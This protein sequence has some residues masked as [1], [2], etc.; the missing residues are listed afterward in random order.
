MKLSFPIMI[1]L[2]I[3]ASCG[4]QID[5]EPYMVSPSQFKMD[6]YILKDGDEVEIIGKSD[7]VSLEHKIDFYNLV[8]V[9]SI[10]TGD[11]INVL[12]TTFIHPGKNGN[13]MKFISPESS[14]GLILEAQ[15]NNNDLDGKNL[16]NMKAKKFNKVLYDKEFISANVQRYPSIIGLI[17]DFT[18][19][20]D[21][22][23]QQDID[24]AID[25]L[26]EIQ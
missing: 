13:Y 3:L 6:P 5:L 12:A 23:K 20:S 22:Q 2:I 7:K 15:S 10:K 21:V 11:T 8:V 9:R 17:G 4:G 14:F 18:I 16:K 19:L 1:L 25:S 24:E 26:L